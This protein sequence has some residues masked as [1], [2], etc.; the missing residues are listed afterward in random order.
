MEHPEFVSKLV[1]YAIL[2]ISVAMA[3]EQ[4]GLQVTLISTLIAIVA[5]AAAFGLALSLALGSKTVFSNLLAKHYAQRMFRPGDVIQV[6]E[7]RGTVLRYGP[8]I[9]WLECDGDAVSVP[10]Q[11]LLDQGI[12]LYRRENSEKVEDDVT[13]EG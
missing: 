7:L 9:V 12:V 2:A 3:A 5:A 11:G 10:C 6:G 1:Y 4:I 8:L 13:P